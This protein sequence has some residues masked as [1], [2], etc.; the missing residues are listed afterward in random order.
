MS[1]CSPRTRTSTVPISQTASTAKARSFPAGSNVSTS[2]TNKSDAIQSVFKTSEQSPLT[3]TTSSHSFLSRATAFP[4]TQ[5]AS[6]QNMASDHDCTGPVKPTVTDRP[7][8]ASSFFSF[9]QSVPVG[10]TDETKTTD[11][12]PLNRQGTDLTSFSTSQLPQ[13]PIAA[14]KNDISKLEQEM[15]HALTTVFT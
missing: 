10:T 1:C 6:P 12:H 2:A 11:A 3:P 15:N 8:A 7:S 4:K 5:L 9:P 13:N 14:L